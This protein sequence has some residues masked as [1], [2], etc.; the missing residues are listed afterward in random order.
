MSFRVSRERTDYRLITVLCFNLVIS[1]FKDVRIE[2]L[3]IFKFLWL[4]RQGLKSIQ[5]TR[6]FKATQGSRLVAICRVDI[7]QKP[8]CLNILR[9][10][11]ND[12]FKRPFC[13]ILESTFKSGPGESHLSGSKG[14][15]EVTPFPRNF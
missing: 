4:N 9:S 15:V 10:Y 11:P 14:R 13:I 6:N 3:F 7:S 8:L 1:K 12:S 2:N 5:R